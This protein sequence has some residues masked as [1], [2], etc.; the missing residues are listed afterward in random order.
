[1]GK[2]ANC[3]RAKVQEPNL[4]LETPSNVPIHT[5]ETLELPMKKLP[6]AAKRAY[7]VKEILHNIMAAAELCDA[8]CG[9]HL[10]KHDAEIEYEGETLYRGWRDKPLR[11]WLFNI[12][13][14][15]G[16]RQT[17]TLDENEYGP[18]LEMVLSAIQ[19]VKTVISGSPLLGST[20]IYWGHF[21]I[22]TCVWVRMS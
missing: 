9:A 20:I 1:M 14:D 21:Y 4:S 16:N 22:H 15:D 2:E 12:N 7:R 8:G 11:L 5:T 6:Q 3:P 13:P 10:Y 17:P 18:A 19:C